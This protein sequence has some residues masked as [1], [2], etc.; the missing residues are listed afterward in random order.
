MAERVGHRLWTTV[1]IVN[2]V[3]TF[4]YPFGI[5]VGL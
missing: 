2:L 1:E 3:L 4:N 5:L